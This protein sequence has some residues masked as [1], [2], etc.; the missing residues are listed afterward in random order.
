M[1]FEDFKKGFNKGYAEGKFK[2]QM[3]M[4]KI[5]EVIYDK[6]KRIFKKDN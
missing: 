6:F 1:S 5:K 3:M 2:E 4:L